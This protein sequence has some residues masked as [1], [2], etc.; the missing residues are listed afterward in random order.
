MQWLCSPSRKPSSGFPVVFG[1]ALV[2]L[3]PS[4]PLDRSLD[5]F[6]ELPGCFHRAIQNDR[7]GNPPSISLFTIPVYQICQF[8]FGKLIYQVCRGQ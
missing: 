5:D 2:I 3:A 6:G 1:R 8:I 4:T 7:M